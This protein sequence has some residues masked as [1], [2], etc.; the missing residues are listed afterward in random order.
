MSTVSKLRSNPS[1]ITLDLAEALEVLQNNVDELHRALRGNAPALEDL[2]VLD[3]N[4]DLI[5]DIGEI[6]NEDGTVS[7][8]AWFRTLYVGGTSALTAPFW[9]DEEGRVFIGQNGFLSV[10]DPFGN[11]VAWLGARFDY[12]EVSGATDNGAGL[13]RLQVAAHTLQTGDNVMV[14]AVGGVENAR[15]EFLVTVVDPNN[16]DLQDSVFDGLY[17]GGGTVDRLLHVTGAVNNGSGLIR[18]TTLVAHQYESGDTVDVQNVGGVPNA[19]GQW[20]IEVFDATHC[21]LTGSTFAGGYSGGGTVLRYAGGGLFQTIAIGPSFTDY[22]L[23]AFPDGT[24]RIRNAE[25]I[26]TDGDNTII[27]DPSIPAIIIRDEVTEQQ[28]RLQDGTIFVESLAPGDS[29]AVQI[30]PGGV[31]LVNS[32]GITV[33]IMD[34]IGGDGG[35]RLYNAGATDIMIELT[36][37]TGSI[38]I[39]GSLIAGG[40]I[41][42][43][44]SLSGFNLTINGVLVIDEDRDAAFNSLNL[45]N[46]L[47]LSEGGTSGESAAEARTNLSVYSK[48]EVDALIAG[49]TVSSSGSHDHGGAVAADGSHTHTIT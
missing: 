42:A 27:L 24:L 48:A 33:A 26:L 21:D 41:H 12:L 34:S 11:V 7:Y 17:T 16:I 47:Q 28:V 6:P 18:L 43:D 14:D 20:V 44:L 35:L 19:T 3:A 49:L 37:A 15:G 9:A 30:G 22:R 23:R 5:A 32:S 45:I 39:L 36:G 46:P 10:L 2:E 38:D 8:G 31:N 40:S 13:I 4:G 1:P 29:Q 25:I